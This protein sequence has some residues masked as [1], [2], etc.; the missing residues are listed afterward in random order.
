MVT[1][2]IPIA[3]VVDFPLGKKNTSGNPEITYGGFQSHG[4]PSGNLT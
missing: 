2:T 3:Q 1:H 4:L